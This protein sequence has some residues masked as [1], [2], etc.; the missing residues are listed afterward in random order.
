VHFAKHRQDTTVLTAARTAGAV[1]VCKVQDEVNIM[2]CA[3]AEG[4]D[5]IQNG[6]QGRRHLEFYLKLK[7]WDVRQVKY[8]V[9]KHFAGFCPRF[10]LFIP[11]KYENMHFYSKMA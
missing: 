4:C 10:V 11:S 7:L 9:I 3:A 6:R 8:D 1:A 2:G 5:A